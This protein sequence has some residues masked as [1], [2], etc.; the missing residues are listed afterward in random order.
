MNSSGITESGESEK[1]L[2]LMESGVRLHTTQYVRDKSTTPSGFTLKLR[3]HIRSKRLEDVRMLGYD[4]IILFQFGLGSNAHFVILELY[5]QGNI[6]L[7]DSE[8]TVLTLLRSHRDDNKGLAIMSRHRYPVEA[9]R[10]F[11]RTDFTKLKDTLMMNAVDDKESSQVTPGSI[12]AQEPSVTP[13]DGVPVTDKSEEPSTTTGKKSA[14]KNKQSSSN[15]KA[16][17][18]APSNKSTL[19]TL[20]G[21]AL[22]Y[23]PA[24]AE[25]IILDAGLLPSTKVGKDPESSIDDHT[26]Q[27]L[28]ES[29]SKFEDWLVDVMSGQRI[30]EGYILMQ[31]KAAAKKNL[32]PLEGSSASQKIYD[33]YCPVLLNQFKSRE[34]NEFETFDAALDEFYSKIE[35]QRVNQQQKSKEDSAA[36]RL[37]KI[38]L[39]QVLAFI[40]WSLFFISAS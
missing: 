4:R 2:L 30:P 34:F 32:T 39:D 35:S 13:S 28:V 18:N 19:K 26:I 25:H 22:A 31:N 3:K 10:V 6:L 15:A 20:L 24:L 23:G 11:E 21:E 14:S 5:A 9:C 40:T 17:N 33:E 1:V 7:T 38:K 29:I 8:Y 12:D 37:N 27:S 36:Q 16:S